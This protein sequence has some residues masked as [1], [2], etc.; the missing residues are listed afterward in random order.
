MHSDVIQLRRS[1]LVLAG[2][3]AVLLASNPERAA[4][5]V[6]GNSITVRDL[7]IRLVQHDRRGDRMETDGLVLQGLRVSA[8]GNS[9]EGFIGAGI[10]VSGAQ[11]F[12]VACNRVS[13][14]KADGIHI[15]EGALRGRVV[16]NVVFN[17][18]DD[19]I[20]VVSYDSR[21]Q[22]S[23]VLIEDNRVEHIPWGRGISVVGSS[24]VTIR[25]NSVMTVAAAAGILVAREAA[26]HT[27]GAE[28]VLI[29]GNDISDIQQ[30]LAPL[31]T[32]RRTGHGA[33]ELNSDSSD[34][35]LSVRN[36][37][38]A[39][40]AI[41]GAARDGVRLLGNV[42]HAS[43]ERNTIDGVAR[44]AIA[45]IQPMCATTISDCRDNRHE[46]GPVA[47]DGL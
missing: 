32:L 6:E 10:F 47:C 39:G 2:E 24:K 16:N 38:V 28:D 43:I 21:R 27:P 5:M 46:N 22:A 26:W 29:E 34:P 23:D 40:N 14:T 35:A 20:A 11:D 15:T 9:V 17:S 41:R 3:Q 36:V 42:C 25:H 31:G 4:V 13:N 30:S 1:D 44:R 7:V 33:I 12:V 45:V 18:E 19:G 37:R 8:V